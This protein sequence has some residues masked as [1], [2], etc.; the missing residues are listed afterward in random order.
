MT[1]CWRQC[2]VAL[3]VLIIA[4]GVALLSAPEGAAVEASPA[5]RIDRQFVDFGPVDIGEGATQQLIVSNAGD[6]PLD[7]ETVIVTGADAA[8]FVADAD[9]CIGPDLAAGEACELTV[10]FRPTAE[11]SWGAVLEFE[12]NGSDSP[13]RVDLTGT[14]QPPGPTTPTNQPE[15]PT[16]GIGE[17]SSPVT[18]QPAAPTR[19]WWLAAATLGGLGLAAGKRLYGRSSRWVAKHVRVEPRSPLP[20][21]GAVPLGG[22][23]SHTIRL[24]ARRD[25][26][27]QTIHEVP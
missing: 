4:A 16:T 3:A 24:V 2:A 27:T 11:R 14:G 10:T 17:P 19:G 23:V 8:A 26:G 22:D 21:V 13:H 7:I 12:S 5:L 6:G 25:A 1:H 15:G 18:A 9:A 20:E